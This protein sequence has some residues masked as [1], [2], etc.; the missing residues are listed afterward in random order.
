MGNVYFGVS[1]TGDRAAVK[2]IRQELVSDDNLRRRFATEIENLRRVYGS[3]VARLEDADPLGDPAW[4]AVQYVPGATVNQYVGARGP[5]PVRLAAMAGAMLADGLARVHQAGV[6]HR[7]LK[8]QNVILGPDG[9]VLIDFGLA[10]LTEHGSRHTQTGLLIGTPAYMS[11]EQVRGERLLTAAV[12]IYALGAT[13]VYATTGHELYPGTSGL[14]SLLLRITDPEVGPDLAGVPAEL[15]PVLT[16]MLAH[17]PAAR[18]SLPAV[19]SRLLAIASADGTD[20]TELRHR[21]AELTYTAAAEL[22]VPRVGGQPSAATAG[23]PPPF[24]PSPPDE[25][26]PQATVGPSPT[27]PVRPPAP[28]RVDGASAPL[29]STRTD[30]TA[31]GAV[32]TPRGPSGESPTSPAGSPALFLGAR[33]LRAVA[34]VSPDPAGPVGEDPDDDGE[35]IE[36]LEPLRAP[37]AIR[38]ANALAFLGVAL[39]ALFAAFTSLLLFRSGAILSVAFFLAM[40]GFGWWLSRF[41]R[42]GLVLAAED[43]LWL[44]PRGQSA[45]TLP[46]PLLWTVS[47]LAVNGRPDRSRLVLGLPADL[48]PQIRR[49]LDVNG[50]LR[51]ATGGGCTLTVGDIRMGVDEVAGAIRRVAPDAPVW[52]APPGAPTPP[53]FEHYPFRMPWSLWLLAGLAVAYLAAH[54]LMLLVSYVLQK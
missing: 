1:S 30:G 23:S 38:V 8:P 6:L 4:L 31:D 40:L 28:T 44:Q 29:G 3:R 17:D 54:V 33:P 39:L 47:V 9:P 35:A 50:T 41:G 53:G 12:D 13:L 7:D 27:R 10:V 26:V 43:G 37:S 22:L 18:P 19:R 52:E 34:P 25:A 49:S 5:L 21:I 51:A 32:P 20:V 36:V 2:V 48:S 42:W 45:M 15:T 46:W 14:H 16:D 11:P 24:P